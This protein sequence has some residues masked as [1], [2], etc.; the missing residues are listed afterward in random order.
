MM[1][2]DGFDDAV[3][4]AASKSS[5]VSLDN[6]T[7]LHFYGLF[8]QATC[9]DASGGRPSLFDLVGRSKYDAWALHAV[10]FMTMLCCVFQ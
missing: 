5:P 3:A 7:R 1:C 8:K 6:N 4:H 10:G 2:P 9:G